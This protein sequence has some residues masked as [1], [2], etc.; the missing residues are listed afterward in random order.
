MVYTKLNRKKTAEEPDEFINVSQKILNFVL[1]RKVHFFI[2]LLSIFFMTMTFS[3]YKHYVEKAENEG[4][5]QFK[6]ITGKYNNLLNT[7]GPKIAYSSVKKDFDSIIEEFSG[8]VSAEMAIVKYGDISFKSGDFNTAIIM[9]EKAQEKFND[10]SLNNLILCNL[11]YSYEAKRDYKQSIKYFNKIVSGA[12]LLKKDEALFS[13]AR[14]YN[15]T[16]EK[17]Q[18]LEAYNK[19]VKEYPESLYYKVAKEWKQK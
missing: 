10:S 3:I 7:S 8:T 17:K 4:S 16:G 19:I 14:L 6:I 18:G 9:Y 13:L 2:G 11:A 12:D 15:K 5:A 1:E